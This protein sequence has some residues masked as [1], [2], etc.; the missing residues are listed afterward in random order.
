[1]VQSIKSWR[2]SRVLILLGLVLVLFS[3]A[4]TWAKVIVTEDATPML[5]MNFSGRD[6]D[7]MPTALCIVAIASLLILGYLRGVSLRAVQVIVAMASLG[8]FWFSL[9]GH[10]VSAKV[11][12]LAANDF[13]RTIESMTTTTYVWWLVSSVGAVIMLVGIGFGLMSSPPT[14]QAKYVRGD[15]GQESLSPWQ[16]LDAGI[17]PTISNSAQ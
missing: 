3:N 8:I 1:M 4:Q 15:D 5:P 14:K 11:N 13:G 17:D 10:D 2:L 6:I 16:S 9:N 12:E 7:A